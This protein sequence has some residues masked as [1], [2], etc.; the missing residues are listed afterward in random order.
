[1]KKLAYVYLMYKSNKLRGR[2][3]N[4]ERKGMGLK[5]GRGVFISYEN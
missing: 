5:T 1:M 2:R 4:E 3:K